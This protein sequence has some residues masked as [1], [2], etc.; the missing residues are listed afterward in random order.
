MTIGP[1]ELVVIGFEGN[2]FHGEIAP[3]LDR[4]QANGTIRII[5]LIFAAKDK[6]GNVVATE[7]EEVARVQDA[8]GTWHGFRGLLM[9]TLRR[10]AAGSQQLGAHLV[11]A[12]MD[13]RQGGPAACGGRLL[14]QERISPEVLEELNT[15]LQAAI[16]T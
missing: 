13:H 12:S 14:A 2:Q 10:W 5:D 1:L 11:R 16:A 8:T 6:A 4:L 3:E 15:E 7:I 9:R